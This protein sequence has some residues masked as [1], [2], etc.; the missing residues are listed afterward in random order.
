MELPFQFESV[1]N[2]TLNII[3][4]RIAKKYPNRLAVVDDQEKLTYAELNELSSQFATTLLQSGVRREQL[5]GLCIPRN[6]KLIVA[7]LG[8]LKAHAAYV[9]I[10]PEY[11][12]ARR[13]QLLSGNDITFVVASNETKDL[14]SGTD[15]KV[16]SIDA[17]TDLTHS[18]TNSY[19]N[20]TDNATDTNGLAYVIFTSGSTGQ[21]KGVMVQ[22]NNAIRLFTTTNDLFRFKEN[23]VWCNFHSIAFDFSVWEIWG[24]LLFGGCL[25]M[26]SKETTK[27][28][29]AFYRLLIDKK[30]TVLNQ[31]PSS[32]RNLI[33][34]SEK[35]SQKLVS[36]RYVVFGGERLD[37]SWLIPWVNRYGIA[38]PSLI[39]MYGI[40]ET[41]V[42]VTWKR[43]TQADLFDNV[44][45]PIGS[46]LPD[47]SI[48]IVDEAGNS[49]PF[50]KKGIM[51]IGG[52]GLSRGYLNRPDLTNER[53]VSRSNKF[54]T[55][56]LWY[57][58]GDI[59]VQTGPNEFA[60]IGRADDQL[61]IR[62]YRIEPSEIEYFIKEDPSIQDCVVVDADYGNGDNRL[63]A[64]LVIKSI[65]HL[66]NLGLV[67]KLRKTLSQ[68]LPIFMLPSSYL[69]IREIPITVNGKLDKEALKNLQQATLPKE[70]S[71]QELQHADFSIN[72]NIRSI[73]ST[74]LGVTNISDDQDFFDL[75]GTSFSLIHMLK[76]IN[77]FY[78]TDISTT[79]LSRGANVSV[80]VDAINECRLNA[81]DCII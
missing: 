65:D 80:L 9:P 42:H 64:Y 75:G 55:H 47:T 78:G 4:E 79:V 46:P 59:G 49:L 45:S 19:I 43:L 27:D 74:V 38:S 81:L 26:V 6:C 21:P 28:P 30:V 20:I 76:H 50:G 66:D 24:A 23:D 10:D 16:I 57:N 2:L 36:L 25:V 32:F 15:C 29:R 63:V 77:D 60:Y 33:A 54:G 17:L 31:T 3:F 58:S 35:E 13:T 72:E 52:A 69:F 73:W 22:H 39:N 37:C 71:A 44:L 11:P 68:K 1:P 14:I 62:G 70:G 48:D 5:V 51:Y 67:S 34:A 8:I 53:F 61:K 40:T 41:T 12:A 7:I 56:E 18:V